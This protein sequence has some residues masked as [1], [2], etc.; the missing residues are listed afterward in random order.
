[1]KH[2]LFKEEAKRKRVA[3]IKS[4]L[5]HKIKKRDKQKTENALL[6]K[7]DSIDPETA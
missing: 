6:E 3:K 2:L 7:L 4:K 1:M 5:Y